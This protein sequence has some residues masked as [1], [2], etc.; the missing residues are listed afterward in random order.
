MKSFFLIGAFVIAFLN[1]NANYKTIAPNVLWPGI[2]HLSIDTS[3]KKSNQRDL[4]QLAVGNKMPPFVS[5]DINGNKIDLEKLKGKIV[6]FDFWFIGC[7]PCR[8]LIPQLDKIA[9]DYKANKDIVF[10]AISNDKAGAL[11]EFLKRE[12]FKY[13]MI[14]DGQRLFDYY[15]IESCPLSLIIDRDGKIVFNTKGL[16]VASIPDGIKE[17]LEKVK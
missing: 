11:R 6:V 4:Y 2:L 17:T 9:D 15:Q 14:G 16:R 7:P 13:Q 8:Y 3:A 1:A 10:I 5:A 12:V